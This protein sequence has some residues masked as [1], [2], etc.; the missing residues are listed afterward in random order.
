MAAYTFQG[1]IDK[2]EIARGYDGLLG[3]LPKPVVLAG[4]YATSGSDIR[5]LGRS[6]HR[7][8]AR[9]P[10]PGEAKPTETA[11]PT[12]HLE[13][14][15]RFSFVM[16]A[17]ALE[18]DRG[19]DVQRMFGALE[20]HDELTVFAAKKPDVDP[21]SLQAVGPS[22]AAPL[23]VE[24]CIDGTPAGTT[25][26]SDKWIGAVCWSMDPRPGSPF[27]LYR[28]PFLSA[29]GRNDWTALAAVGH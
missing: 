5:L 11:L 27:S 25:C 29:D 23:P 24:L 2:L 22:W 10:F 18:E 9:K 17:I 15:I 28:L 20:R 4:V 16:L 12:S 1:R 14:D 19:S 8:D 26:R 13:V 3:G 7:F 6:L 21:L